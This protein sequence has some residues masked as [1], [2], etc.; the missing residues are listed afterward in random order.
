M[1]S[2]LRSR[3]PRD[4]LNYVSC[5]MAEETW[6][7]GVDSLIPAWHEIFM[8]DR[9]VTYAIALYPSHRIFIDESGTKEVGGDMVVTYSRRPCHRSD[10]KSPDSHRGGPGSNLGQ[11]MCDLWWKKW[12]W[13]QAFCESFGFPCLFSFHRLLHIHHHVSSGLVQQ[14]KQWLTH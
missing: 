14:A 10:G 3:E 4:A 11:I 12:H 2:E 6:G 13:G 7:E 5:T 9:F 8:I 1:N